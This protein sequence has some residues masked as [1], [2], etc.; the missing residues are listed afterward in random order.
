MLDV[1]KRLIYR[2]CFAQYIELE[3]FVSIF[4]QGAEYEEFVKAAITDNEVQFVETND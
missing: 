4:W 2:L 1:D 3:E